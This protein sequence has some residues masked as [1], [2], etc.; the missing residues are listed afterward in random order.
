MS[1]ITTE[2]DKDLD[3]SDLALKAGLADYSPVR[4]CMVI[5]PYGYAI[6]E[7]IQ[8]ELNKK[9]KD[10]GHE[11]AYFPML[12][13]DSFL[14]KEAEHVEGFAPECAVVTHAGGE[15]LEEPLVL[16]PT[17]E[18]IIYHM[19]SK[20]IRS[21]RDLPYSINQWANVVRWEKRT[22]LF[23]RTTEF[24]WQE[25]HTA[26]AD[27]EDAER[28]A[29]RMLGVYEKF[30]TEHLALAPVVGRKTKSESFAGA[31]RTYSLE[32]LL[33][34]GKILQAGTSHYLGQSF[35]KAFDIKFQDKNNQIEHAHLTSWG[36]STRLIG[37]L[38]LGHKD[39]L[40]LILPPKV[41]PIQIV[42]IPIYKQEADKV[43]VMAACDSIF[44]EL[45]A[46]GLR[47]K[48][49][50]NDQVN[51]GY[52]FNEWE[53]K[54]V[55]LRIQIGARDIDS[56]TVELVRRDNKQK[57]KNFPREKVNKLEL[58]LILDEIQQ[59]LYKRNLEWRESNT[60]EANSIDEINSILDERGGFVKVYLKDSSQEE[61]K[62]KELTKATI[63]VKTFEESN[64]EG[65]SVIS[66]ESCNGRYYAGRAY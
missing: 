27:A 10:C 12:I 29:K 64:A 56:G 58:S 43:K 33:R 22:R 41:A 50:D 9:F 40:G 28:E 19:F 60:S 3:L 25:G 35:A 59:A 11:N 8:G 4:G 47:V 24:L 18:T 20:W 37:A 13:P 30:M 39:E 44:E 62:L 31:E 26:H 48:L 14:K 38:I 32:V 61:D 66:G 53:L 6:W 63:R 7:N 36:V 54:G 42:I 16:R 15:Q 55:P 17:S 51:P 57:I 23:L 46:E 1:E 49:D 5:K 21:W 65:K 34:D 45:K 2:R 52:K